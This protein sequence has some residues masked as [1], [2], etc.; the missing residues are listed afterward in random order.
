VLN[1]RT[2]TGEFNVPVNLLDTPILLIEEGMRRAS[3]A[4]EMVQPEETEALMK[5]GNSL[6]M[7]KTISF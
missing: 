4:L 3:T 1:S 2:T 5:N 6:T 7:T